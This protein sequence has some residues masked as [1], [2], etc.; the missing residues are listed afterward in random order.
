MLPSLYVRQR[1]RVC[2]SEGARLCRPRRRSV[3][4]SIGRQSAFG[5]G[6]PPGSALRS[7]GDP[8]DPPVCLRHRRRGQTR[9]RARVQ[10]RGGGLARCAA[11]RGHR[12]P[13][14]ADGGD[15]RRTGRRRW[16]RRPR[17]L[18]GARRGASRCLSARASAAIWWRPRSTRRAEQSWDVVVVLGHPEFYPRFGFV[19]AMPLGILPPWPDIPSEA[20]MVAELTP[21]AL[22]SACTARGS[23]LPSAFDEVL[24]AFPRAAPARSR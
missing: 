13:R 20:W 12:R 9:R 2:C 11:Q 3:R 5:G 7:L 10:W 18:T 15:H 16:P 22:G 8:R 1:S 14:P 19:P 23:R 24:L 21:R 17:T 4:R 6:D